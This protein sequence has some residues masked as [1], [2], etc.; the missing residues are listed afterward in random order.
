MDGFDLYWV[1]VVR[2]CGA[3]FFFVLFVIGSYW[4]GWFDLYWEGM[5]KTFA[6]KV[7]LSV[8]DGLFFNS[9]HSHVNFNINL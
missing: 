9:M 4:L 7:S 8:L 6:L 5:T 2:L 1:G 3:T